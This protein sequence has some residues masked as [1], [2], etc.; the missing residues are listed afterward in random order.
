[1]SVDAGDANGPNSDCP[2]SARRIYL[3]ANDGDLFWLDP[4]TLVLTELGQPVCTDGPDGGLKPMPVAMTVDRSGHVLFA[5]A[6]A[7]G[8]WDLVP[9]PLACKRMPFTISPKLGNT[10]LAYVHDA[11]GHD[12][13]YAVEPDGL[14][15]AASGFASFGQFDANVSPRA[16]FG[17]A[18][19]RLYAV[20]LT[21]D[22]SIGVANIDPSTAHTLST[23]HV[24]SSAK[25]QGGVA[26]WAGDLWVFDDMLVRYDLSNEALLTTPIPLLRDGRTFTIAASST[27]APLQ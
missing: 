6:E 24:W 26:F 4:N 22:A 2:S 14:A 9:D 20:F 11:S 3:V 1:M 10:G 7:G 8:V 23:L 16:L 5:D 25:S 15:T 12:R 19:G 21:T 27:C 17:T 13:L 18:D